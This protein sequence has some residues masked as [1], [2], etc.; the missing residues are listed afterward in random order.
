MKQKHNYFVLDKPSFDFRKAALTT[1]KLPYLLIKWLIS[2]I[3]ARNITHLALDP[4]N[5]KQQSEFN[6]V[7]FANDSDE[8]D[9]AVVINLF[10]HESHKTLQDYLLKFSGSW[11]PLPFVTTSEKKQL[12]YDNAKD[13]EHIDKLI[14]ELS[15]VLSGDSQLE[16][17][18]GKTFDWDRI[19][20]KGINCLDDKM[21]AYFLERLEQKYGDAPFS[22]EKKH[23]LNFYSV[24]T[25][26]YSVLDSVEVAGQGEENKPISERKFVIA[27]L[28][29]Q[30]NY[31]NWMKDF[32][33]S[34]N[35]IGCTVV[36]FNYRGVDYSKGMVW[37]QDNMINDAMAQVERLIKLGARPENIG[38]EGMCIGGAVATIAAAKLHD[39]GLKV[40]LYNER[41]FRSIPRFITGF[42]FPEDSASLWNPLN[43]VRSIG[44]ILVFIIT[45]P[46]IVIAGWHM[47]AAK[48]WDRIPFEDKDFSQIHR[49]AD[50]SNEEQV[51][52]VV[53]DSWASIA[54]HVAERQT[55][56]LT[57]REQSL[58]PDDLALLVEPL[59]NHNFHVAPGVEYR[60]P[61]TVA[62]RHLIHTDAEGQT[63]SYTMHQHMI[64]SFNRI[65]SK[66]QSAKNPLKTDTALAEKT[67]A[68]AKRRPL[69]IASSGGGG[70][71][72]AM[73]GII[74]NLKADPNVDIE[75]PMH[76]ARLYAESPG[77]VTGGFLRL[78]IFFSSL[79]G[80]GYLINK[81]ALVTNSYRLP[82]Y[83]PFW[84]EVERIDKLEQ[85]PSSEP[86]SPPQGRMRPYVD[87]LL[88]AHSMGYY[89]AAMTNTLHRNGQIEDINLLLQQKELNDELNYDTIY[90]Y[91]LNKLIAAAEQNQPYTE[92][93][94]TQPLFL[95]ALCDAVIEYN[96]KYLPSKNK[97]RREDPLTPIEIHQYM[98]DLPSIGCDH[99]LNGLANLTPLQK[100]QLHIYALNLR[101]PFLLSYLENGKDFKGIHNIPFKDNP[102][103]RRGFKDESLV[104]Y[105]D[106][107]KEQTIKIKTYSRNLADSSWA[108]NPELG[109]VVV[110]PDAK[111]A[112]I[113]LSSLGSNTTV[114]YI[115]ELLKSN[116]DQ[117]FVFGG[118]GEHIYT[119]VQ[120]IIENTPQSEQD[121]VRNRII[122][123]GNQDDTSVAP[124]MTRSDCVIIRGGMSGMEQAALPAHPNKAVFFDQANEVDYQ[125]LGPDI[126][127][128]DGNAEELI[129]Y[130]KT[131]EVHAM[132]TAPDQIASDLQTRNSDSIQRDTVFDPA[133]LPTNPSFESLKEIHLAAEEIND[134][135]GRSLVDFQRNRETAANNTFGAGRFL[136]EQTKDKN[137]ST[138]EP[139]IGVEYDI[140]IQ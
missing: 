4:T 28:A 90:Y 78:G 49:S 17:F 72:F 20:F 93:I 9:D 80:I 74:D 113:M 11:F 63:Q 131:Q 7:H 84:K 16:K 75:F 10:P 127:W 59:E 89:A 129:A 44:A 135:G 39:M 98:T 112:A 15:L 13:R 25:P 104:Q 87:M 6:L 57:R 133:E 68:P 2:F 138:H 95:A 8:A 122:L 108:L 71:V 70:H 92:I 88:D 52:G 77:S 110:P 65:F 46:F 55:L 42:M 29:R 53:H 99:Y 73:L 140:L 111:V 106:H 81:M 41:S 54:S 76:K 130:L 45:Y 105:L 116:Y 50:S 136:Q 126:N 86:Q 47:D 26:D 128:E 23:K 100:Q 30:Q 36:G 103:V 1:L 102:L 37:T 79:W 94:S 114:D 12:H 31:I 83:T 18:Q 32:N 91:F 3:L 109:E 40:K 121:S 34:A 85:A 61:H 101:K 124:I 38:L 14:N 5:T 97:S 22:T 132:R 67:R 134:D 82:D 120:E 123:L 118:L 33:H 96:Q 56:L 137:K 117:I 115:E 48:A 51:D 66:N 24:E 64:D 19:H 62:R 58:S 35:K 69:A 119:K 139:S 125:A 60:T 27:C 21:R 43:I 107:G